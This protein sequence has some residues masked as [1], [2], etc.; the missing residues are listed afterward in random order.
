MEVSLYG[1]VCT[2]LVNSNNHLIV[3]CCRD[4]WAAYNDDKLWLFPLAV[5]E[6]LEAAELHV[7]LVIEVGPE[8]ILIDTIDKNIISFTYREYIK[9]DEMDT[10]PKNILMSK[11]VKRR[12]TWKLKSPNEATSWVKILSKSVHNLSEPIAE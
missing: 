8:T 1:L 3:A 4:Y 6:K 9:D 11:C 5:T 7:P 12:E 2:F 10:L